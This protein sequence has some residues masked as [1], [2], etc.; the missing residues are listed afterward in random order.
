MSKYLAL[1][2]ARVIIACESESKARAAILRIQADAIDIRGTLEGLMPDFEDEDSIDINREDSDIL[3]SAAA[4]G[5]DLK[6]EYMKLDFRSLDS[7]THFAEAYKTK[8]YPLNLLVC[9]AGVV[10]VDKGYT[11]DGNENHL[12]LNYLGHFYLSILAI[13]M[14]KAVEGEARIV[15]VSSKDHT[16]GEFN[17]KNMQGKKGY[18][19]DKFYAN[20]KFYQI[21]NMYALHRRL[22]NTNISVYAVHGG[23]IDSVLKK[24]MDNPAAWGTVYNVGRSL[25]RIL[26]NLS[27][28]VT[29]CLN[30]SI[31]PQLRDLKG[32][33]FV[34]GIPITP[35]PK[36]RDAEAQE[37][38]WR[39]SLELLEDKIDDTM[40]DGLT[41][42]RQDLDKEKEDA[43]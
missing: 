28:N 41:I 43:K 13:P 15:M 31:S 29:N 2:G 20:S 26:N 35:A 19:K 38:L 37:V 1:L 7:V 25:G 23:M 34:D 18:S 5:A 33:F 40:M 8:G 6:V 27:K 14:M 9:A 30:V 11:E 10:E 39:R 32:S 12:Q 16:N 42:T 4:A 17:L 3:R 24:N 36:T 21:M 22:V